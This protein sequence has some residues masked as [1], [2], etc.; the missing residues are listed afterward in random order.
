[1]NLIVVA[2]SMCQMCIQRKRGFNRPFIDALFG[3][4]NVFNALPS[5]ALCTSRDIE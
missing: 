1:M 4:Y 3:W 2:G 5:Y